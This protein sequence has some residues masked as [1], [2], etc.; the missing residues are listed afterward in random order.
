MNLEISVSHR[1]IL[2]AAHCT[3]IY[4]DANTIMAYVGYHDLTA[5]RDEGVKRFQLKFLY[6][7]GNCATAILLFPFYIKKIYLYKRNLTNRKQILSS[8]KSKK[9]KLGETPTKGL[10]LQYFIAMKLLLCISF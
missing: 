1:H 8:I 7:E 5:G 4:S 9:K 2:T 6:F 10:W 3:R